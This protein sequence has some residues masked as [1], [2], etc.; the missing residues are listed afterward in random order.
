MTPLAE[1]AVQGQA[2]EEHWAQLTGG[3]LTPW[4]LNFPCGM[5]TS[6]VLLLGVAGGS[7]G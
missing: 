3:S 7:L 4:G 6:L 1:V 2:W 5:R